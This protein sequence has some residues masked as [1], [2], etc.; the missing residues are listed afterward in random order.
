MEPE[1]KKEIIKMLI[2]I[3]GSYWVSRRLMNYCLDDFN[4]WWHD[5]KAILIH[6]ALI[7]YQIICW[8]TLL[9]FIYN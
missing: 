4:V 1:V 5:D 7:F 3:I 9:C 8:A 2:P 6:I